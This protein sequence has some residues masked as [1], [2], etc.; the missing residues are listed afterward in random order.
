MSFNIIM[1]KLHLLM[2]IAFLANVNYSFSQ[3]DSKLLNDCIASSGKDAAYLKD[4]TINLPEATNKQRPPVSKNTIILR[5]NTTYRFTVCSEDNSDSEAIIQLFDT[6]RLIASTYN[7]KTGK[8]YKSFNFHC[9][10]TGPYNIFFY[11]KEGKKGN[12]V[13]ILSYV[14]KK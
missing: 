6:Q 8:C 13:G 1:K 14:K 2:L 7:K 4:F 3:G 12:A 9:S 10:K 11:F 5:K